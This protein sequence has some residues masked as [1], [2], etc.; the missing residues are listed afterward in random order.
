MER[1]VREG[2]GEE[3]LSMVEDV[4]ELLTAV[5]TQWGLVYPFE[6]VR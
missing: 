5:R 2:G 3:N 4:M 1:Y 6:E